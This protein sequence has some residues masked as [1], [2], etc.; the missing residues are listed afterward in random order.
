MDF[1]CIGPTV[2]SRE[3]DSHSIIIEAG[4]L[5]LITHCLSPKEIRVGVRSLS[6][7][8]CRGY[9]NFLAG[10]N[11]DTISIESAPV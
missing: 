8:S 10:F 1:G 6:L 7:L 3:M 2:E 11:L 4:M 9:R 5:T